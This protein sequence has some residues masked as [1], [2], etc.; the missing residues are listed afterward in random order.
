MITD[1]GL[2]L[3]AVAMGGGTI[4]SFIAIGT[5]SS[6]VASGNTALLTETDRNAITTTD[7]SVSR[8]VTY[9]TDLSSTELSGTNLKEFGLFTLVSGGQ[10]I[11]RQVIGSVQFDGSVE[12]QIQMTHKYVR[13]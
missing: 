7:T 6:T 9:I 2:N 4:P 5:G 1:T 3:I 10:I 12:L 13:P 11:D 8:E